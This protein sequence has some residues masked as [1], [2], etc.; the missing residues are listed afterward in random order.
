[1]SRQELMKRA[2]GF[3]NPDF[4]L[5]IMASANRPHSAVVFS[6]ILTPCVEERMGVRYTWK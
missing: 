3:V 6:I 4:A 1:M 2:K 5:R